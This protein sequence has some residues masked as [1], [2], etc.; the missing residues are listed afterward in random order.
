MPRKLMVSLALLLVL[1]GCS[2]PQP[3]SLPPV[4]GVA[5]TQPD[6]SPLIPA[7]C[8]AAIEAKLPHGWYVVVVDDQIIVER[9]RR[10]AVYNGINLPEFESKEQ[11]RA[12]VQEDALTVPYRLVLRFGNLLNREAYDR[13]T[14]ANEAS[15][16][17]VPPTKEIDRYL[18]QHPELPYY[19][20]P[21][22]YTAHASIYLDECIAHVHG[23][24][25]FLE[26]AEGVECDGVFDAVTA[27][28]QKY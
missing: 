23:W 19:Q 16:A 20:L 9:V 2:K 6:T 25:S 22:G 7:E 27:L 1:V 26:E 15:R 14:V 24:F 10:V 4:V 21:I 12:Y 5:A 13:L 28:F 8:V 3:A 17:K 18:R 11:L